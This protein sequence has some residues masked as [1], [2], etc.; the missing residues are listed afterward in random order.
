M[1]TL[2]ETF[3]HWGTTVAERERSYPCDAVLPGYSEAYYRAVTVNAKPSVLFRWLC[4][5]RVAPY[6]YDW[7][8]NLG[9]RSPQKLTPGL[10]ELEAG[11]R[12]M[13]I[14]DLVS[15]ET[16]R[17]LTIRLRNPRIFPPLAGTYAVVPKGDTES[18]LVVKLVV[19]LGTGVRDRLANVLL[20][21]LDWIMMRRQL[22]NLKALAERATDQP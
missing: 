17:H 20:P 14:F 18:R 7:I 19:R 2:G 11:Q 10:D 22:L 6:S 4:Q 12:M 15:F 1:G 9:R 21:P 3:H 13:T 8:D 5:M 16:H